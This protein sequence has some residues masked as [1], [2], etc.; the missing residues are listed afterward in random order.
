MSW[1]AEVFADGEA[2]QVRDDHT[3]D[4][5]LDQVLDLFR[6]DLARKGL[7]AEW[8]GDLLA[9]PAFTSTITDAYPLP[10]VVG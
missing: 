1:K 2:A 7:P 10:E 3:D 6:T 8:S 5:T 9:D 4:L